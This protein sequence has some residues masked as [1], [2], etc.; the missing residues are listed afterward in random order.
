MLIATISINVPLKMLLLT[1]VFLFDYFLIVLNFADTVLSDRRL[2]FEL[3]M[4]CLIV[5]CEGAGETRIS[6]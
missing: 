3:N 6:W 4:K 5:Y 2:A 1:F